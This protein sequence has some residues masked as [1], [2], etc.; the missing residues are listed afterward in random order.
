MEGD[1]WEEL[2]RNV[3]VFI[4][5]LPRKGGKRV[6]GKEKESN[7]VNLQGGKGKRLRH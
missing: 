7:W 2:P 5:H 6:S 3:S 4:L 1:P